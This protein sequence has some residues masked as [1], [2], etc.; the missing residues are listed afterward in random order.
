MKRR[1]YFIS[2]LALPLCASLLSCGKPADTADNNSL[3]SGVALPPDTTSLS[4]TQNPVLS[5]NVQSPSTPPTPT[6]PPGVTPLPSPPPITPI[7]DRP[8]EDE[9]IWYTPYY[10]PDGLNDLYPDL[11]PEV[12]DVLLVDLVATQRDDLVVAY[13]GIYQW[14][15]DFDEKY[16]DWRPDTFYVWWLK[17][18]ALFLL[19][20]QREDLSPPFGETWLRKLSRESFLWEA[21]YGEHVWWCGIKDGEVVYVVEHI[22]G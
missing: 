10:T 15:P 9:K 18:D 16:K 19:Y 1:Y 22:G 4:P 20:D 7:P 8:Q 5:I 14:I 6:L 13:E 21:K 3:P 17:E 12:D 11:L 2:L